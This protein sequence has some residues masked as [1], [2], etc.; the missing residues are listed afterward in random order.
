[1]SYGKVNSRGKKVDRTRIANTRE[2]TR[3]IVYLK[4]VK[5]QAN[6]T[7]IRNDLGIEGKRARDA[8]NW[9]VSNKIVLC[10]GRLKMYYIN[11]K[12]EELRELK[13]D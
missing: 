10:E 1:M 4:E 8:W 11:Q 6:I 5:S 3:I 7:L 9:L 13:D 12:F 2:L